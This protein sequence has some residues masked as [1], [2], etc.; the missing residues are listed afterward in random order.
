VSVAKDWGRGR[1]SS[2]TRPPLLSIRRCARP[3]RQTNIV[4]VSRF[5]RLRPLCRSSSAEAKRLSSRGEGNRRERLLLLCR[6]P[7]QGC[8]RISLCGQAAR[9]LPVR[10][11]EKQCVAFESGLPAFPSVSGSAN[12]AP[13]AFGGNST[14]AGIR[15]IPR[16]AQVSPRLRPTTRKQVTPFP[17]SFGEKL[18][19][20]MHRFPQT[21]SGARRQRAR[22]VSDAHRDSSI[23]KTGTGPSPATSSARTLPKA[24]RG[25][26]LFADPKKQNTDQSCFTWTSR[27][28]WCAIA[29]QLRRRHKRRTGVVIPQPG[30][31]TAGRHFTNRKKSKINPVLAK[32][33]IPPARCNLRDPRRGC[34]L[35]AA[36]GLTT[37][38]NGRG[39]LFLFQGF[40][41]AGKTKP[42]RAVFQYTIERGLNRA[43]PSLVREN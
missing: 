13:S 2:R 6:K 34:N 8:S 38:A 26:A 32:L 9:E 20:A 18:S 22:K 23:S 24:K 28:K 21:N 15:K 27:W 16:P 40:K 1:G 10:R 5:K 39:L 29:I 33:P 25:S 17:G 36:E 31:G 43:T 4:V 37:V 7:S 41:F 30:R 14:R 3:G 35:T 11:P 19:G 42:H 12:T